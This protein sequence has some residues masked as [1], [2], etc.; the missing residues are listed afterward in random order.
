MRV[1][2]KAWT[3]S[4]AKVAHQS[5]YFGINEIQFPYSLHLS[6]YKV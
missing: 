1:K 4:S 2:L 5:K 3:Y 6:H